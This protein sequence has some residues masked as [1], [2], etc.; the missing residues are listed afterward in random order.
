MP[1]SGSGFEHSRPDELQAAILSTRLHWLKRFNAH[2][3]QVARKY[4][5]EINCANPTSLM[6]DY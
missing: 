3:W 5:V 6:A 4:F 1:A 2:R